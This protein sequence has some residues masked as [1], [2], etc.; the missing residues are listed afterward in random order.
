MGTVPAPNIFADSMAVAQA[1][2]NALAE[3][4]RVAQLKQQTALEQQQTQGVAQE[5]QQRQIAIND[6][7]AQSA[8]L[9]DP[10]WDGDF[11]K[12]ADIAKQH[13]ISAP[14]YLNLQQ[15]AVARKTQLAQLDKDQ[16]T[17]MAQHHDFAIGRLDEAENVPDE[18]L[19]QHMN[20]TV[21]QL[22]TAGHLS[23]QE[24]Q[25][26]MQHAQ[27]M[28]PDQFRPWLDVYK[29]SLMGDKA[30]AE[31]E[32]KDR[33]A[34]T[35]EIQAEADKNKAEQGFW[36]EAGNGLLVNV[37]TGEKI[38]GNPAVDQA[39]MMDWLKKNPKA[40][41]ADFM[42]YKAKLVPQ[43]NFNLQNQGAAVDAGGDPSAIARAIANN[44]MKW[45]DAVSPRTP[46]ATKNRI[47][48]EVFKLNPSFDTSEFGLET[49][50]AK[51]ARSGAW[52]DTRV[53]YNTAL[54]H[55]QQLLDAMDAMKN[56]DTKKLNSLKNFFQ[57]EFGSPE[58]PTYQAIANAY[59][60]EVTSVVSKGHI[61][62]KEVE[63][64][65][66]VLPDNASPETIRS[67]VGAYNKLMSSKRDELDKIIKAG[68]GSKANGV[69]NTGSNA[70]ANDFFSKFGG[71]PR[72][73]NQ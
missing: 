23:P 35:K 10:S 26:V 34:T 39:E 19:M 12:L 7:K 11:T 72:N 16:L 20:D 25:A 55:S 73:Q 30:A 46:M 18:Q 1:P 32:I 3:Y 40:G 13:G 31:Q 47:L 52:A 17:N 24:A 64:G 36:K 33:D 43:F 53:A 63:T 56:M 38:Q 15:Q 42:A 2:R 61:T 9:H 70:G 58:V 60:H 8:A 68:A 29:K 44:Q 48:S 21:G 67:V 22:Q 4:A 45:S 59:N 5:N 27:S 62:D 54:D 57:T 69:L 51:K 37:K 49:D 71:K 65:G 28:R 41:P 14:G 50:A 6:A 66:A